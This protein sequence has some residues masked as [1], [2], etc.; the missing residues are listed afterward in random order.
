[1]DARNIII[2]LREKIESLPDNGGSPEDSCSADAAP[3]HKTRHNNPVNMSLADLKE[4]IMKGYEELQKRAVGMP[5]VSREILES[6][7]YNEIVR[8]LQQN[9]PIPE[10]SDVWK[11]LENV[12]EKSSPGFR[13]NLQT[14]LGSNLKTSE[15]HM[16]LL[17]K[18]G[19]SPTQL[20]ILLGRAKSTITERRSRLCLRLTSGMT[21]PQ[22]A[23]R[24]I[25]L[26]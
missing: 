25:A 18:S 4:S 23:D 20:S 16:A 24:I 1:M 8:S 17:I 7:G 10:K 5:S 11:K 15:Y 19:F 3:S 13:Y 21:D 12:V 6:E 14:L 26:L 2:D 22:M 9:L